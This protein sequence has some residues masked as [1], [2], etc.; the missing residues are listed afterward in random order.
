[1]AS[2]SQDIKFKITKN[3]P[4]KKP[5]DSNP[6]LEIKNSNPNKLK[7]KFKVSNF[8]AKKIPKEKLIKNTTCKKKNNLPICT[9]N[10]IPSNKNDLKADKIYPISNDKKINLISK[11]PFKTSKQKNY[12]NYIPFS[13]QKE[14]EIKSD[15]FIGNEGKC[16][17]ESQINKLQISTCEESPVNFS[18]LLKKNSFETVETFNSLNFQSFLTKNFNNENEIKLFDSSVNDIFSLK[19][20]FNNEDLIK[21]SYDKIKDSYSVNNNNI[22]NIRHFIKE[23]K[24]IKNFQKKKSNFFNIHNYEMKYEN[25][26]KDNNNEDNLSFNQEDKSKNFGINLFNFEYENNEK[27]IIS[28]VSNYCLKNKTYK[29]RIPKDIKKDINNNKDNKKTFSISFS[30]PDIDL[31]SDLLINKHEINDLKNEENNYLSKILNK[32]LDF[33]N[34]KNK[35]SNK[36]RDYNKGRWEPEE[37]KRFVEA[38]F[39]FGNEWKSV[40][41]YVGTRSSTQARSHAQKFLVKMNRANILKFNID[42][43]KDSIKTLHEIGISLNS[44]EYIETIKSLYAVAFEKKNDKV[45]NANLISNGDFKKS[46]AKRKTKKVKD[47]ER[48]IVKNN[49]FTNDFFNFDESHDDDIVE[50]IK[51]FVK[52]NIDNNSKRLKNFK[53]DFNSLELR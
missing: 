31:N 46:E 1:M 34:L 3:S 11:I 49:N 45:T 22:K 37:H 2:S 7:L 35:K 4:M 12:K 19:K 53:N 21:N 15:I 8:K 47:I 13:K 24:N 29:K 6:S 41:K 20:I 44:E 52:K 33:K 26:A 18:N 9:D 43:T 16:I 23:K 27:N 28:S 14:N 30:E 17:F 39:K 51:D 32:D 25:I 5:F 42:I 38:I 36:E 50:S 48:H 40:Q 10:E